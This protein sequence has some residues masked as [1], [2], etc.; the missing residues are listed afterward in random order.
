M[1]SRY[2]ARELTFAFEY[3]GKAWIVPGSG[4]RRAAK[5]VAPSQVLQSIVGPDGVE[6]RV[7]HLDGEHALLESQ[8][9][10]FEGGTFVEA[11]T[12]SFGS[13]G[14]ITFK[15]LGKGTIGPS[16]VKGWQ[17]GAV[18]WTVTGGDGKF[19]ECEGIVTSNFIVNAEGDVIDNH[20]ARLYFVTESPST[21]RS[22]ISSHEA[23]TKARQP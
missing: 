23:P 18:I 19:A 9:E 13:A 16:P 1:H 22:R 3:R 8:I 21:D 17:H 2:A 12:I 15:T 6:S 5:T 7:E 4:E 10:R 14:K 11:G 20:F